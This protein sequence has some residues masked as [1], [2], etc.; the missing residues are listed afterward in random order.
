MGLNIISGRTNCDL[1][2]YFVVPWVL[3]A[4]DKGHE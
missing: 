4:Y 2:Q 3:K 1:N